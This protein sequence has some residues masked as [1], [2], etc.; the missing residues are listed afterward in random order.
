MNGAPLGLAARRPRRARPFGAIAWPVPWSRRPGFA[1]SGRR[2]CR[3]GPNKETRAAGSARNHRRATARPR[4]SRPSRSESRRSDQ[5]R[6]RRLAARCGRGRRMQSR[7]PADDGASYASASNRVR[8]AERDG[9]AASSV[10]HWRS[11]RRDRHPPRSNRSRRG[12]SRSS[13]GTSAKILFTSPPSRK[14]LTEIG[15]VGGDVDPGQDHL[16]V[17]ARDEFADLFGR[18]FRQAPTAIA[19]G[20]RE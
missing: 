7:R 4:T 15:A 6:R 3:G 5:R 12:R 1:A 8:P 11:R 20:Q 18:P 10:L 14:G 9:S 19:R 13:S 2:A 17:P 16:A